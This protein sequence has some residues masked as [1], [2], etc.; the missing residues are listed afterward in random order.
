MG[1]LG[2]LMNMFGGRGGMGGGGMG[3]GGMGGMGGM[4]RGQ[5]A[6]QTEQ[7][8]TADEYDVDRWQRAD[9]LDN[10][11]AIEQVRADWDKYE[12]SKKARLPSIFKRRRTGENKTPHEET[13]QPAA[14][15]SRPAP[16]PKE[17]AAAPS[18]PVPAPIVP[19][20][21]PT[22]AAAV[23]AEDWHSCIG[24]STPASIDGFFLQ[25]PLNSTYLA[26]DTLALGSI[27]LNQVV[28]P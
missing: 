11:S 21:A 2:Q 25:N 22:Q 14:Q 20:A 1:G 19:S 16:K 27:T 26:V 28:P 7:T 5:S 23:A 17:R 4:N 13:A 10:T 12:Q 6:Q 3:M 24:L 15:P 8:Q 9:G 18:A